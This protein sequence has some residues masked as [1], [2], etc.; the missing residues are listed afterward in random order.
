MAGADHLMTPPKEC[1]RSWP[2][3][4]F[5]RSGLAGAT[6]HPSLTMVGHGADA[7][8]ATGL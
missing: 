4:D 5:G 6:V 3:V 8:L 7:T 2:Q 1:G